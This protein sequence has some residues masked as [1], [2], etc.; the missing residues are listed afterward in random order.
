M[1]IWRRGCASWSFLK[2]SNII[3][4]I[5]KPN[6]NAF[7]CHQLPK[8]LSHKNYLLSD[9]NLNMIQYFNNFYKLLKFSAGKYPDGESTDS[10]RKG[11]GCFIYVISMSGVILWSF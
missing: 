1:L 9:I 3:N 5:I 4:L 7:F 10:Q 6:C 2:N 11:K 8:D